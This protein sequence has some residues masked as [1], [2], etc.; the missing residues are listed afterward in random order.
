MLSV[1]T[2]HYC[3]QWQKLDKLILLNYPLKHIG[4]PEELHSWSSTG[5]GNIF[6]YIICRAKEWMTSHFA[7]HK[8]RCG[9][10]I[11]TTAS[12]VEEFT[13]SRLIYTEKHLAIIELRLE[14]LKNGLHSPSI[15][16]CATAIDH[17]QSHERKS[18]WVFRHRLWWWIWPDLTR[19]ATDA[20]ARLLYLVMTWL[21]ERQKQHFG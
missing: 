7:R 12:E 3:V 16:L 18:V 1:L 21:L 5:G 9:Q 6:L 11:W 17:F 8:T 2:I 14:F 20:S 10:N 19:Y 15:T 4:C 13:T